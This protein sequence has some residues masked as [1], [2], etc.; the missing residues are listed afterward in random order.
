MDTFGTTCSMPDQPHERT[1]WRF[2]LPFALPL[3]LDAVVLQVKL[4]RQAD[5]TL[6]LLEV[7]EAKYAD[8]LSTQQREFASSIN[9]LTTVSDQQAGSSVPH[10]ML[11]GT[12]LQGQGIFV[13]VSWLTNRWCICCAQAL[14]SAQSQHDMTKVVEIAAQVSALDQQLRAAVKEAAQINTRE[15]L[16]GRPVTDY[17]QIK[18]LTDVFDPFVQFWTT[19]AAWKVGVSI[20]GGFCRALTLIGTDSCLLA[21]AMQRQLADRLRQLT[22]GGGS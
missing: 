22:V 4:M 13:C 2:Q 21:N 14:V 3:N 7:D 15:N 11:E 16:L 1:C 8:D 6:E 9:T 10:I 17:S 19:A 12:D 20:D 5:R 18:Q